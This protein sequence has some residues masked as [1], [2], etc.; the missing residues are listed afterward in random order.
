MHSLPSESVSD[1]CSV[2]CLLCVLTLQSRWL[3]RTALCPKHL[4]SLC[5]CQ[6]SAST[7]APN[8]SPLEHASLQYAVGKCISSFSMYYSKRRILRRLQD[9]EE[10]VET[11]TLLFAAF[12]NSRYQEAIIKQGLGR[13]SEQSVST[14]VNVGAIICSFHF[15]LSFCSRFTLP[16]KYKQAKWKNSFSVI[17]LHKLLIHVVSLFAANAFLSFMSV[18]QGAA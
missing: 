1:T 5:F 7:P 4:K 14:F 15:R 2:I 11:K 10:K 8:Q 13:T 16:G 9:K 3:D 17:L 6:R 18:T 12:V